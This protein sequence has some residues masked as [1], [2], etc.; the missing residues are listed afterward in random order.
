MGE[1]PPIEPRQKLE[2]EMAAWDQDRRG[3]TRR[4]IAKQSGNDVL[5]VGFDDAIDDDEPPVPVRSGAAKRGGLAGRRKASSAGPARA[6]A[7]AVG[8]PPASDSSSSDD[9]GAVL[10]RGRSRPSCEWKGGAAEH[11]PKGA[12][13]ARKTS[14][15]GRTSRSVAAQAK[16]QTSERPVHGAK[17]RRK[18]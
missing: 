3:N 4:R 15:L 10:A 2:Q 9:E 13:A 5:D 14:D 1:I 18:R 11:P 7:I 17:R 12:E 8:R 16:A 6:S